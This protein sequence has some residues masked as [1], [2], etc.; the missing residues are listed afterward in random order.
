M[1]SVLSVSIGGELRDDWVPDWLT[2][3]W[4]EWQGRHKATYD[5]NG[6]RLKFVIPLTDSQITFDGHVRG[7]MCVCEWPSRNSIRGGLPLSSLPPS[8]RLTRVAGDTSWRGFFSSPQR[9]C[10][11]GRGDNIGRF[12][13][14]SPPVTIGILTPG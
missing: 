11:I 7:A 8:Y 6:N 5:L 4:A 9:V 13:W 10:S 12:S 2:L 14:H 3:D 1:I